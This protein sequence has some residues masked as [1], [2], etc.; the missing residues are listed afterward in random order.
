MSVSKTEELVDALTVEEQISLLAGRD[1][2]TTVPIKR[3]G[4]P[5]IKVSDGPNGA[6]GGGAFV[7]GVTAAAFP[8]AIG[9]AATWNT[10]LVGEI[11]AALADEARSKG[12]RVLLAPTV[13]I[14]RSTLNG[15]NFECYSEDPCLTSEIAVAYIRGLQARGIGATV[16]HFIGNESEYQR[17][18]ISSDID[19]RTLR[20][21]YMPPFEAAV[22]RA[23]TWAV[24]TSYNRLNGIYVSERAEIVNGVLKREW[25]FDGLV[26]S[27]WFG[28]KSTIEAMNGGLDLEMPGPPRYRGAKLL[29]AYREG[30]V[31]AA[32]GA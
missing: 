7:G 1:F 30:R 9:L 18:T 22:K 21:I 28:T 5:S 25:G 27:D 20:E 13:N 23:K 16:K 26:M 29:A 8:V 31:S 15:R 10:D 2:W 32:S 19:E 4:I 17:D 14:H 3:L 12:A 11:G 24:M 6:R